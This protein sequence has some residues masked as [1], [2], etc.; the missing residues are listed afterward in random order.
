MIDTSTDLLASLI[1]GRRFQQTRYRFLDRNYVVY[2][3]G[4]ATVDYIDRFMAAYK[5]PVE[6]NSYLISIYVLDHVDLAPFHAF[7]KESEPFQMHIG[8]G[9]RWNMKAKAGRVGSF[10]LVHLLNTGSVFLIDAIGKTGVVLGRMDSF[11]KEDT[12][13]LIRSIMARAAEESGY[14]IYHSGAADLAGK[15]IM[16]VGESGYGKTTTFLELLSIGAVPVSNDRIFLHTGREELVMHSWPS[17]INTS[18]GTL[19]KYPEL[20]HLVPKVDNASLEELWYNKRKIPIEPPDFCKLLN[21]SFDYESSVDVMI[22]PS[23]NPDIEG[24]RL[25][26]I[27]RKEME[28][29]LTKSCYSPWDPAYL[30]WHRYIRSDPTEVKQRARKMTEKLI[31]KIPGFVL[32]GGVSLERALAQLREFLNV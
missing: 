1:K 13:H 12:F 22:F 4:Q 11:L 7:V 24:S 8:K 26:E 18:V 19:T 21:V 3:E 10:R 6:D 28:K 17:F 23:L 32:E 31:R 29:R 25:W 2:T 15:G 14:V 20:T 27:S 30:D 16:I 9:E 5:Q